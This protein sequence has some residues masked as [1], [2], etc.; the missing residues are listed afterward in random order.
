MQYKYLTHEE[1]Q[2]LEE[3]LLQFL[4]VNGIDGSTWN[5]MNVHEPEKAVKLVGLFSDLVW[6]RSLEKVK[7]GELSFQN[8]FLIFHFADHEIHLIGLRNTCSN[9]PQSFDAWIKLLQESPNNIELIHQVKTYKVQREKE[10]FEMMNNGL[11]LSE[12]D[13]FIFL[14]NLY[15][16]A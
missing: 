9:Q 1:L 3:E 16:N 10:I 7:Y 5:E 4:I 11:L 13:K 14:Q 2:H 8:Q 12:P 15:Q 6:Q